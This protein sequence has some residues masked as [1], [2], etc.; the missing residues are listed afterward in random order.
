MQLNTLRS[1]AVIASTALFTSYSVALAKIPQTI[2]LTTPSSMSIPTP[3][4]VAD[5]KV[6]SGLPVTLASNTTS[7]CSVSGLNVTLLRPGVCSL[8]AS[9]AGNAAYAVVCITRNI[10]VT[11]NP[12]AAVCPPGVFPGGYYDPSQSF[13]ENGGIVPDGDLLCLPGPSWSGGV[14]DPSQSTCESGAIVPFSALLCQSGSWGPGGLFD[15]SES[16]CE[17]GAIVPFGD[18]FC[19]AGPQGEGGIYDPV[20]AFCSAGK[21]EYW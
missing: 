11:L 12:G 13:C 2:T 16:T 8:T 9:Q 18:L 5:V 4:F 15:P 19:V 7:I 6:T 10:R 14:Y 20:E 17:H 21:I 1:S 3:P